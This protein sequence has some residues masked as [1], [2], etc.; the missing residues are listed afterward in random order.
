[1]TSLSEDGLKQLYTKSED[2]VIYW[3]WIERSCGALLFNTYVT[4]GLTDAKVWKLLIL[5]FESD[6]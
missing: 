6:M 2:N 5:L 1:M 4:E 3:N